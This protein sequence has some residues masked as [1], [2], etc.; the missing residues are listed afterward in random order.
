MKTKCN[1]VCIKI[2]NIPAD[3]KEAVKEELID[4][5]EN[6]EIL[7]YD[8]NVSIHTKGEWIY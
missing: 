2:K 6:I 5:I 4:V 3:D 1:D 8:F 7:P